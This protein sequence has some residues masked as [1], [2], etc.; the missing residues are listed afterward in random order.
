MNCVNW[1]V[2]YAFCIWDGGR[3]PTEAEWNRAAAGGR[4]QRVY[5]WSNP[6][7][8]DVITPDYAVYGLSD[9]LPPPVGSKPLG[10][11]RWDHADLAGSLYEWTLDYYT[12]PYVSTQCND[13]IAPPGVDRKRSIRGGSFIHGQAYADASSREVGLEDMERNWVGFRCARDVELP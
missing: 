7:D 6:P 2:A 1:Y 5:P 12:N 9:L 3:L 8:T 13:C 10:A 4:E 11:A